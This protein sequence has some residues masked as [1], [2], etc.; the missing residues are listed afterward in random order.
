LRRSLGRY[1]YRP[2]LTPLTMRRLLV[3]GLPN[4]A[5]TLTERAPGLMLPIVVTELISPA[6]NA[7]WYVAWMMAWVVFIIPIQVGLTTFAEAARR[8]ASLASFVRHAIRSS[9]LLGGAAALALAAVAPYILSILGSDYASAGTTPLRILVL[10]VI[11]LAF[12]QAYFVTCRSTGRLAEAT[13]VGLASGAF[14]VVGAALAATAYGLDGMAVVWLV[15]QAATAAWAVCR[16]RR[17]EARGRETEI[18]D[19]APVP[20]GI[21]S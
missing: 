21:S 20:W 17:F 15:T 1:R 8:P 4:H 19:S 16:L 14:G 5:L 11:P 6:A 12:V 7:A 10:A 13:S 2:G 9:L 3:T 18:S